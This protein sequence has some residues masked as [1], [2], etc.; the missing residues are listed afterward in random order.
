MTPR[1]YKEKFQQLTEFERWTDE[2]GTTRKTS[3]R[4]QKLTSECDEGPLLSMA[5][6]YSFLQ[7]VG[8]TLV[9]CYMCTNVGFVNSSTSAAPWIVCKGAFIQDPP[10]G[11]PSTA[12]SAMGS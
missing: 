4:R 2:N 6:P 7:A 9:Y 11:K 1:R 10:Q 12:A 5:P 3:S 8:S